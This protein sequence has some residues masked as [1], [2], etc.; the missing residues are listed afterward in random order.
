MGKLELRAGVARFSARGAES[1]TVGLDDV[2]GTAIVRSGVAA[3]ERRP[4]LVVR[5]REGA[6]I[7][8]REVAG[9]GVLHELAD[10]FAVAAAA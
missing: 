10:S 1:L 6:P 8:V 9:F 3:T 4:T 2:V 7:F 5:R